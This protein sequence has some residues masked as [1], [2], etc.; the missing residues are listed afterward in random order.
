MKNNNIN[1]DINVM[2][3]ELDST[4]SIENIEYDNSEEEFLNSPAI[5][6]G[7]QEIICGNITPA[8]M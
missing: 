3:R 4:Q 7:T 2:S 5:T 8:I 6:T 1:G